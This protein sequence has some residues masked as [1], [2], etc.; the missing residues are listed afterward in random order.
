M[1]RKDYQLIAKAI[2]DARAVVA[3]ESAS[4]DV[5]GGANAGFYELARILSARFFEEN[6]RFDDKKWMIATETLHN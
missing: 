3:R 4:P 5:I 1:T 2:C 6:P